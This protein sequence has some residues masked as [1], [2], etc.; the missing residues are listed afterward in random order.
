MIGTRAKNSLINMRHLQQLLKNMHEAVKFDAQGVSIETY[1]EPS[2]TS[3]MELFT[4]KK[5]TV[6]RHLFKIIN[7]NIRTRFKV[8]YI[9]NDMFKINNKERR[10]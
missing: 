8:N 6:F 3:K 7:R 1:S 2:Q 9:Q 10:S 5:L 4:K